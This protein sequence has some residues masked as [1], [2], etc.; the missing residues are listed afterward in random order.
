MEVPKN[1]LTTTSSEN[2]NLN[3]FS[4][5]TPLQRAELER[6]RDVLTFRAGDH[7]TYRRASG[8][9][10]YYIQKGHLSV[11]F[12]RRKEPRVLRICGPDDMTGF[13]SWYPENPLYKTI[14]FY[15]LHALDEG[16]IHF[17]PHEN[18]IKLQRSMPEL[19]DVI[20]RALCRIIMNQDQRL[21]ALE[22]NSVKS[23]VIDVLLSLAIKFGTPC[24]DG[25][26][27]DVD[28]DRATLASLAG[29]VVESF[30]RVVTVLQ[31][32]RLVSRH[33]RKIVVRDLNQLRKVQHD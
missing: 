28:I 31:E 5:L 25:V 2:L 19:N 21:E 9:G 16:E 10:F 3:I 14:D 24:P 1:L 7:F 13:G 20:L 22:N 33:R 8:L 15:R 6:N 17:F 11:E 23:R 4:L 26:L 32:E 18:F 30:S 27:I 12:T 29:T